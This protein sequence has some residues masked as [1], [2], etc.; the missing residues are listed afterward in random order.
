MG[1]AFPAGAIFLSPPPA[2]ATR[3]TDQ[4]DYA[5]DPRS[6][7]EINSIGATTGQCPAP[8]GGVSN[9][10]QGLVQGAVV[11]QSCTNTQLFVFGTTADG[12][13]TVCSGEGTAGTWVR[14][15]PVIGTRPLGSS[16]VAG[17]E[18]AAQTPDG[19]PVIC[20]DGIWVRS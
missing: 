2:Q 7:A 5:N 8:V 17:F 11:G 16:C 13:T 4:I 1:A 19:L 20:G 12:D 3:C 14:S 6:N 15:V 18:M 10:V 9:D